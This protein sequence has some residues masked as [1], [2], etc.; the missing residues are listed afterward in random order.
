[1]KAGKL[2][3]KSATDEGFLN[4]RPKVRSISWQWPADWG[5]FLL[6]TE[7]HTAFAV[8]ASIIINIMVPA[9]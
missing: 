3:E 6:G 7:N 4:E 5:G 1:M 2:A 9:S 8:G